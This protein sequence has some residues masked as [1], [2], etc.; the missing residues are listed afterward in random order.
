MGTEL[1]GQ[2]GWLIAI[3]AMISTLLLGGATIAQIT[4]PDSV[5]VHP[6]F[7][8]IAI[9]YG[10]TILYALT[11]RY[12]DRYRWSVDAQLAC[13]AVTVSAFIFLTGGVTS[14]F[15]SLYALPIIAASVIQARRGGLMVA[16]LSAV[17]YLGLVLSQYLPTPLSPDLWLGSGATA[18]P[19]RAAAQYVV[20]LN[21]FG[22]FAVALLS[23]S[24]AESV[25]T[26]GLRLEQASTE[27]ADL[28]AL[29]Q[30]VIDSL[31]SGLVTTDLSQRVLTFN[32]AAEGICGVSAKVVVSRPIADVLQLPPEV[33]EAFRRGLGRSGARRLEFKFRRPDG[34]EID[35]GLSATHVDT[36]QRHRG[37]PDH[38]PGSDRRQEARKECPAPAAARRGRRDGG[39]HRPRNPQS[40]RL[41]V[42]LDPD[43]PLTICR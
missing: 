7:W 23:G 22:F 38:V 12:V 42:R 18:L 1:R 11:L 39:R 33:S 9:T 16:T 32:H 20:G 40:P 24:M 15:S 10:L 25:R 34:K 26:T 43:P 19:T 5:A 6:F 2:I 35:V 17:L 28:Q 41:D 29:N 30:N 8:L 13:D 14:F 4:S 21:I 3:R 37:P 27:L 31:P 36:P